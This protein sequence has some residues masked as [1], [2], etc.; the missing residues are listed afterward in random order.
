[1]TTK[2]ATRYDDV[3]PYCKWKEEHD[4]DVLEVCLHGY[5]KDDIKVW[6]LNSKKLK[7]KGERKMDDTTMRRFSK[8]IKIPSKCKEDE[9]EAEFFNGFLYVIMPKENDDGNNNTK[10]FA[11]HKNTTFIIP[12]LSLSLAITAICVS[13][14]H[15]IK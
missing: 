3:E 14:C 9:I 15:Y 10:D 1:M 4:R 6:L 8:E 7:I 11:H 5:E 12:V 2:E 13:I